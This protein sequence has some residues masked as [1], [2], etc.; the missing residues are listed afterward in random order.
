[1]RRATLVVLI[2]VA[3]VLVPATASPAAAQGEIEVRGT[4]SD[5]DDAPLS[6]IQITA[7]NVSDASQSATATSGKNGAFVLSVLPGTYDITATSDV[8]KADRAHLGV[9]L[10]DG[11]DDIDFVMSE[12][13]G[14]ITG[15]VTNGTSTIPG[16]AVIMTGVLGT[17][18]NYSAITSAPLGSFRI[19]DVQP[20]T[21]IVHAEKDGYHSGDSTQ[22]KII[23]VARDQSI[24]LNLTLNEQPS[25]LSGVVQFNDAPLTGVRVTV[26]ADSGRSWTVTTSGEGGYVIS[27]IPAGHYTVTF[28][29]SGYRTTESTIDLKPLEYNT[30]DMEMERMGLPIS[31]GFLSDYDLAHSLMIVGLGL[32]ISTLVLAILVR[33]RVRK[34]P[35][36]LSEDDESEA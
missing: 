10:T 20:G 12:M 35:D 34:R 5:V 2:L 31:E 3:L 14:T 30:L 16:A 28:S 21:Y 24:S 11:T 26:S 7:V 4:V 6:G 29:K 15:H 1:M 9:D 13:L 25:T 23:T 32:A 18:Y 36:L 33:Y 19:D 27:N 8:Y 17:P 22:A